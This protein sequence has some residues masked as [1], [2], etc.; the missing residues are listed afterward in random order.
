[1][2]F[3]LGRLRKGRKKLKEAV[4]VNNEIRTSQLSAF[5][6]N[7]SIDNFSYFEDLSKYIYD[8]V[9]TMIIQEA[10]RVPGYSSSSR[11]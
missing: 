8:N 11:E 4:T 6:N 7:V 2:I 3:R 5:H 1:M 9:V 10:P